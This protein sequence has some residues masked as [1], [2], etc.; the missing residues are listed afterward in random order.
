MMTPETKIKLTREQL[1]ASG[2]PQRFFNLSAESFMGSKAALV[3]VNDFANNVTA[4]VADSQSAATPFIGLFVN[5]PQLSGKTFLL[6][7]A[8]RK[9]LAVGHR[10]LYLTYDVLASSLLSDKQNLTLSQLRSYRLVCV[11]SVFATEVGKGYYRVLL[12]FLSYCSDNGI[13][14]ALATDMTPDMFVDQFGQE[15]AVILRRNFARITVDELAATPKEYLSSS[16]L[17][18]QRFVHSFSF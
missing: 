11:D 1:E 12:R 15:C 2:L 17:T 4:L 18:A 8:L 9:V 3:L 10:C 6:S 16:A 14:V 7:Y 5:G 13:F